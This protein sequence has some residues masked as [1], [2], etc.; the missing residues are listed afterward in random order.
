MTCS[1]SNHNVIGYWAS[2]EQYSMQDL[3]TPINT[4]LQNPYNL[5]NYVDKLA[6]A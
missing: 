1:N 3:L 4:I 6:N 5:Q 2:Q